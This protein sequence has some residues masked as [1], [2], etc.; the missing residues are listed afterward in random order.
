MIDLVA[1]AIIMGYFVAALFFFRY[2]R[3]SEDRLF[4][5]FALAFSILGCQRLALN[6][7]G[8]KLEDA[9]SFYVLRLAAFLIILYAIWDKNRA[10]QG[11]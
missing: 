5:M 9:T 8:E 3:K 10:K 4:C 7:F 1:G 11:P 6:A 2:W